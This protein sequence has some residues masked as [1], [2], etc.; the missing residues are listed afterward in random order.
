MYCKIITHINYCAFTEHLHLQLNLRI[1]VTFLSILG[2][3]TFLKTEVVDKVVLKRIVQL[4]LFMPKLL[5]GENQ[6]PDFI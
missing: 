1:T 4:D 2:H 5:P 3:G 6:I